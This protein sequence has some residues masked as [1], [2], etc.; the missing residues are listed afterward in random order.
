MTTEISRPVVPG[1]RDVAEAGRGQRRDG[2]VQRIGIVGD[3]RVGGVLRLVDDPGHDEDEDREVH[4]REDDVLVAP[5]PRAVLAQPRQQLI[6][7]QQPH[8]AQ[9]AQEAGAFADDRRQERD[10]RGDVGPGGRDAA[11]SRSRVP[12]D[13]QAAR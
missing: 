3:L 5:K 10:D 2:E 11:N 6:G 12:A 4:D 9:D 13:R 8:R 7:A 1:K